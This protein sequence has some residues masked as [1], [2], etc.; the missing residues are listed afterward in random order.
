MVCEDLVQR[1]RRVKISTDL[2][3]FTNINMKSTLLLATTLIVATATAA[4]VADVSDPTCSS[5]AD[6]DKVDCGIVGS[7]Q[8]TCQAK[9]CCWSPASSGSSAPWCFFKKG[10]QPSCPLT[11]TSKG[12]PFSA[13]EVT[14]MRSYFLKNINIDGSGA[15]VAAPDYNTPGG[16][17]RFNNLFLEPNTAAN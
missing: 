5:I 13:S 4:D 16:S 10:Q 2:F 9:G 7:T 1:V 12:A 8:S 11:Y 15:V 3:I 6:P 14:T 17:C